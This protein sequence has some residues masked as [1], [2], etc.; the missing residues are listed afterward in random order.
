MKF[1][2]SFSFVIILAAYCSFLKGHFDDIL[3]IINYNH[4]HYESIPLLKKIYGTYFK[5]IVFY[6]PTRHDVIE[7]PH[8]KGFFSYLCISDAMKSHP[9]FSGYLF[10]HDDCILNPTLIKDLDL[11]KIWFPSLFYFKSDKGNPINITQGISAT[12]WWYWNSQWGFNPTVKAFNEMSEYNK[13]ILETNWEKSNVVVAFT[14]IAYIPSA[15]HGQFIELAEIFGKHKVFLEI[16]LPTILFS[17]SLKK[18]WEWLPGKS[19]YLNPIKL[20]DKNAIFNHPLKLSIKEH[21]QFIN[22]FFNKLLD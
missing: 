2:K 14:D 12:T 10:L 17:L 3:L 22:Q 20:F 4:A 8:F 9:N 11:K 16:A 1:F 6:G 19:N 21:Q 18:D 7:L 5:N 13:N 15:Y